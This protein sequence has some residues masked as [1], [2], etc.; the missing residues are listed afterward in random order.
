MTRPTPLPSDAPLPSDSKNDRASAARGA[1]GRVVAVHAQA[2]RGLVIAAAFVV[3]AVVAGVMS[4]G[5]GWWLPL[6]LFVVGGLLSAISATTQMLAV[7][8]SAA[9]ASR[10][11]LAAA[12]RWVLAA[13]ATALVVGRETEQSWMFVAGGTTVV[14]AMLGL[15][16]MLVRVRLQAVTPRF[17]PAIEAYVVATVAGAAGMTLGILLG[18]GR[19]GDSA[20]ELRNVHLVLNV[21]GLVGL[22]IAGTLPFFTATQVR[23]KMSPRATP[24]TMRVTFGTLAAAVVV[25]AFGHL[26]ERPGVVAGGLIAYVLGLIGV[27]IMLPIYT[28]SRLRW[29]GPR[30]FQL[31]AGVV[32]WAG[33]TVALGVT[34][35]RGTADRAILQALVVGGF[36][37]ILVASIA[38]LGPV[39]RGGGHRR[40]TAGFAATRSWLSVAAGNI[41]AIAALVGNR[42]TLA[43]ALAIWLADIAIRGRRLLT[44]T[45]SVDHV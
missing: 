10:P 23:S 24:A 31:V 32:W 42:P 14:V 26:V 21:F 1:P 29:A 34:T 5:A 20:V 22:V 9:P 17:V 44:T 35:L 16:S 6:H 27:A 33:M 18:V 37:Q 4:V 2:R 38:Y 40:L 7:T 43:A 39:L 36:A 8:W 19:A 13:G 28:P 25:A 15:A 45:R 3:A 30:L 11:V 41:A 12:Q